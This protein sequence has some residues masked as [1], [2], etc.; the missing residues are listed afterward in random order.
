VKPLLIGIGG[1]NADLSIAKTSN[2]VYGDSNPAKFSF[3]AG[4]VMR[5]ICENASRLGIRT[6]L[7]AAVGND[8]FGDLIIS[9]CEKSGIGTSLLKRLPDTSSSAYVSILDENGDMS[10]AFSDMSIA[11]TLSPE[12]L[13]SAMPLIKKAS[14]VCFDGNPSKEFLEYSAKRLYDEGIPLFLDPVST[15]HA[16][17][18]EGFLG[19]F[20]TI[21]PNRL[22]LETL[23]GVKITDDDS[24]K[25]AARAVIKKGV[26]RIFVTLGEKGVLYADRDGNERRFFPNVV[27]M[28]NANGAGDAFTAG[29]LSSYLD[30]LSVDDT[31]MRAAACAAVA[32]SSEETV[33]P[34]LS[35]NEISKY[36]GGTFL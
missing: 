11:K 8:A 16:V 26:R 12:D 30:G 31:L 19:L 21:K 24:L 9:S 5:N 23:S 4:G 17:K 1:A 33:S 28:K 34:I 2:L 6:E 10:V 7:F 14:V 3:S 35:V 22:E 25:E 15:A 27:P 13:E 36:T 18:F 29:L 32:V 20:D